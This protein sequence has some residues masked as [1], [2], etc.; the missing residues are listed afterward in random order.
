MTGHYNILSYHMIYLLL[1]AFWKNLTVAAELSTAQCCKLLSVAAYRRRSVHV[2]IFTSAK[3]VMISSTLITL[4]CL[5]V[6]GCVCLFVC[7][8]VGLLPR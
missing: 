8:F 4:R 2:F 5:W 1:V 6:C 7:L 3:E